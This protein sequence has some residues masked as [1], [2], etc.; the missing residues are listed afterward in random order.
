MKAKPTAELTEQVKVTEE[1][2]EDQQLQE[3]VLVPDFKSAILLTVKPYSW[4]GSRPKQQL[5]R[6]VS[7]EKP[8]R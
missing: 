1:V 6:S 4:K 5:S 3:E 2:D 7:V 8:M